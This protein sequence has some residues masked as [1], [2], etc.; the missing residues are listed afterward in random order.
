MFEI[1][2]VDLETR[3]GRMTVPA[4]D[5]VIGRSLARYGEWAEHEIAAVSGLLSDG[6]TIVDVG[7]N[8]GNHTLA[9]A[10]RFP[11]SRVIAIEPQ[12][13]AFGLL[14]ANATANPA[15]TRVRPIHAAA[16]DRDG[17]IWARFDYESVHWNV[18]AMRLVETPPGDGA[19]PIP[20]VRLDTL[21]GD[22]DVQF[23]KIDVEGMEEA[24][25]AGA[26]AT[27][28][29]CRPI[30]YFEV[31]A[32]DRLREPAR[33]LSAAGYRLHW[34]ETSAFDIENHRGDRR[35]IWRLCEIGVLAVP[36]D[37]PPGVDLPEVT[38]RETALPRR[39]PGWWPYTPGRPFELPPPDLLPPTDGWADGGWMKR[40][41]APVGD[42]VIEDEAE[43]GRALRAGGIRFAK[44]KPVCLSVIGWERGGPAK[45]WLSLLIEPEPFGGEVQQANFDLATGAV[46]LMSAEVTA[47][48][49]LIEPGRWLC[50]ISATP[51]VSAKAGVQIRLSDA[52]RLFQPMY[53]GD[54]KSGLNLSDPRLE[55]ASSGGRALSRFPGT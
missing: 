36:A 28:R 40:G 31:L 16:G 1:A 17:L 43:S 15:A 44:G 8:I 48:T 13:F 5:A 49:V 11:G 41:L 6:R 4:D 45:R 51:A 42:A 32:I 29:R 38:G 39:L 7:A 22:E 37:A 3:Y 10:S 30:I 21:L 2:T 24:V 52:P 53:R 26:D 18:G 20:L 23:L 14:A 9:F 54:G 55:Q 35:N 46:T 47:G 33:Q 34:L 19:L 50:W 25:L 27:I 12:P